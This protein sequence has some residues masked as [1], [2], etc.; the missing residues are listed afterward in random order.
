[1]TLFFLRRLNSVGWK[2]ELTIVFGVKI[3]V[4]YCSNDTNS[5]RLSSNDIEQVLC[6]FF[7][8]TILNYIYIYRAF[9]F[10]A[11]PNIASSDI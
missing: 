4:V 3:S 11:I 9:F 1:M 5:R 6:P 10:G 8:Q 2:T 7:V